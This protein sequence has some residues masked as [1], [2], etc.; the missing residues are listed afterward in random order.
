MTRLDFLVR[1]LET[2]DHRVTRARLAVLAALT[3]AGSHF[4]ADDICHRLPR[5]GRA[6]VFRTLKLLVDLGVVCRVLLEDGSL[7]YRLN[8]LAVGVHHHHLVCT[9]CGRIED[10]A[11][12]DITL[13]VDELASKSGYEIDGHWLELYGRCQSCRTDERVGATG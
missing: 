11:A 2:A 6:T 8:L 9:D 13:S 3:E 4:T 12:R 1:R 5:V 7:H 10:V